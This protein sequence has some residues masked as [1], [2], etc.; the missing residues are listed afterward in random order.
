[1]NSTEGKR[2]LDNTS[3][4]RGTV[5][6]LY[7]AIIILRPFRR[8]PLL[9]IHM[10]ARSEWSTTLPS[11]RPWRGVDRGIWKLRGKALI[12]G[13]GVRD[14]ILAMTIAFFDSQKSPLLCYPSGHSH[15]F[16]LACERPDVGECQQV[17]VCPRQYLLDIC[18]AKCS[19]KYA[20]YL[21][22]LYSNY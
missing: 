21:I 4:N 19:Y 8:L 6:I 1:M 7:S 20:F 10:A 9:T 3:G 17:S 5:F 18:E 14:T 13:C 16:G 22:F 15:G 2:T 11:F 12:D